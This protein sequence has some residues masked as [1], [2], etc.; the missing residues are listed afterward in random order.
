MTTDDLLARHRAVFPSRMPLHHDGP[1][2]L[3]SGSG[4]A[5]LVDAVRSCGAA[6]V[7]A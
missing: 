6:E 7:A 1:I 2:E 5:I 4:R 3:V